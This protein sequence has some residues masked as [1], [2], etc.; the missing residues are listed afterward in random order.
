[1]V[2]DDPS[3]SPEFS[4]LVFGED[5]SPL[6]EYKTAGDTALDFTGLLSEPLKLHEDLASG[7]GG[8]TWPAG[9][10]LAKHMLRYHREILHSARMFVRDG[11]PHDLEDRLINLIAD[12]S[13][14]LGVDSSAWRLL[15]DVTSRAQCSSLTR[16]RCCHS[17]ST[18]SS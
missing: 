10:V 5:L 7:C 18:T 12:W 4:P 17:C 13:W 15:V 2:G 11:I 16:R 14:E 1:M 6:P 8:Q 3:L 9:M